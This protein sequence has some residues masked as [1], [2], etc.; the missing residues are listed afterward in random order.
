MWKRR[1]V[2]GRWWE[3]GKPGAVSNGSFSDD[4]PP[5]ALTMLIDTTMAITL[6]LSPEAEANLSP[7]QVPVGSRLRRISKP[8]SQRRP[9]RWS[10]KNRLSL[11]CAKGEI[12]TE[13]STSFSTAFRFPQE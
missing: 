8:S 3:V 4:V 13:R 6:D 10:R 5:T 2:G 12:W 1:V 7:R 9:L 11:F